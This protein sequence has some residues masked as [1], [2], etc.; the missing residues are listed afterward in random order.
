MGP[1]TAFTTSS[2]L[3]LI[4]HGSFVVF[5]SPISIVKLLQ[6]VHHDVTGNSQTD[7][8][9]LRVERLLWLSRSECVFLR[10]GYASLFDG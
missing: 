2:V 6:Q 1:K 8:R 5:V 3:P 4:S 7:C 9:L 10:A